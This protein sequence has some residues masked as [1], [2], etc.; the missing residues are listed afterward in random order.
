MTRAERD[1]KVYL[2][3]GEHRGEYPGMER[4]KTVAFDYNSHSG[5]R[6]EVGPI[7]ALFQNDLIEPDYLDGLE[8]AFLQKAPEEWEAY[9]ALMDEEVE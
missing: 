1:W 3:T 9:Q 8:E 6:D 5:I 7:W 2:E 4:L